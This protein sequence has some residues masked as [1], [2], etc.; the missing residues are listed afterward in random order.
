MNLRADEAQPHYAAILKRV[1]GW[2]VEVMEGNHLT[3][4][5]RAEAGDTLARIGDP[6]DG[7]GTLLVKTGVGEVEIPDIVWC[8]IPAGPF[9]MGGD[10]QHDGKPKFTYTIRQPYFI[11]RYPI[12]NAQFDA[13]INDPN[14]YRNDKWWTPAGREWRGERTAPDKF[15]GVFDLPNHPVVNV[16]W[17]EAYAFTRW[18]NARFQ[19]YDPVTHSVRVDEGWKSRIENRKWEIRLPTEAEWEKAAR[20]TDARVYP[21][22]SNPDPNR[23]NFD[24]TRLGTTNAVGA[25]PGGASPYGVLEMSGNVW[26]W[27]QTKWTENYQN[28]AKTE[29]N[30]PKGDSARVVR[31]G[32]FG[33]N[34]SSVRCAVRGWDG[35]DLGYRGRGV[36]VVLSPISDSGLWKL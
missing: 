1:R 22:G 30:D 19:I 11:S 35:P 31:G 28:Y 13:F 7:V 23:M 29:D 33:D 9:V 36:R 32:S 3:P 27:C 10:G 21:W 15:G 4:R 16:S 34:G 18:L 8:E 6:R 12:T 24:G 17:Y 20:G 25:F 26:E 14:G 2:L 5:E